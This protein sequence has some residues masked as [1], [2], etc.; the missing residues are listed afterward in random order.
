MTRVLRTPRAIED[1]VEIWSYIAQNNE[2]AADRILD[3]IEAAFYLLAKHRDLG[4]RCRTRN[5]RTARR[6]IVRSWVV[7]YRAVSSGGVEIIR[8][9]HAART[10]EGLI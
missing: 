6:F 9:L 1:L 10:H 2:S 7:Y 5:S 8:V 3:E 4:E